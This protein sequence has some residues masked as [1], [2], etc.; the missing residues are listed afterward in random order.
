MARY[1][2]PRCRSKTKTR[3]RRKTK[4]KSDKKTS[5]AETW[6]L[7]AVR[8]KGEKRSYPILPGTVATTAV[9]YTS[10]YLLSAVGPR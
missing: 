4:R 10:F 1:E 7:R 6:R 5:F 2:T 3:T 9:L 8:E